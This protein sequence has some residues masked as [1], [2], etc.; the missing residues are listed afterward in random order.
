MGSTIGKNGWGKRWQK[1]GSWFMGVKW[2]THGIRGIARLHALALEEEPDRVERLAL[3]LAERRHELLQLGAAL[4]LEKHL[5]VVVRHLDVEVLGRAG[6]VRAHAGLAR[7]SVL[8]VVCHGGFSRGKRDDLLGIFGAVVVAE[9][10]RLVKFSVVKESVLSYAE[11][12]WRFVWS[13]TVA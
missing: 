5:V 11:E 2:E 7:A 13:E 6:S 1:V 8:G 3:P 12:E 4:D 9:V 10:G